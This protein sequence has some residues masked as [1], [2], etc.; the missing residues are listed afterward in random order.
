MSSPSLHGASGREPAAG[1]GARGAPGG[2]HG[3]GASSG[4]AVLHALAEPRRQDLVRLLER[5]QLTQRDLMEQLGL[6]QPLLSHHLKVLRE[7]GLVETTI[8][9]RVRVYRL[10]ADTLRTLSERLVGMAE[11]AAKTAETKPC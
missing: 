11:R 9:G 4:T 2:R 1:A 5:R 8:C 6:S 7:A 10:R 3:V